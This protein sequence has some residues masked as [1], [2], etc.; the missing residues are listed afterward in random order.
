MEFC[1]QF[2]EHLLPALVFTIIITILVVTILVKGKNEQQR[3]PPEPA[4]AIPLLGHLHL[5]GN[6]QLIHRALADMADKYG[7]AFSIR[8]G[9]HRALVYSRNIMKLV[10]VELLSSR[11]LE[12]LKHV[13]DTETNRFLKELSWY[14]FCTSGPALSFGSTAPWI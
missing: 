5:L 14:Q 7:P 9:I 1:M 4:G 11:R 2:R 8:L 6:N 13:P 10:T 12:L 3:R